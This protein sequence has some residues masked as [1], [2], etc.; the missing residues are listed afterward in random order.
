MP[1]SYQLSVPPAGSRPAS[2]GYTAGEPAQL[3]RQSRSPGGSEGK[4][5]SANSQAEAVESSK[6]A[7]VVDDKTYLGLDIKRDL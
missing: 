4:A 3:V 2:P 7:T 5:F 1:S 6:E